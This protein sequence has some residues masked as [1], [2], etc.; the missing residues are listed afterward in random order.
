MGRSLP[1]TVLAMA[2]LAL[3][4]SAAATTPVT[5]HLTAGEQLVT[6]VVRHVTR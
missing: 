3:P 5:E 4:A 2:A 6:N 1:A